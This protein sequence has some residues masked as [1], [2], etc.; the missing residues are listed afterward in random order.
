MELRLPTLNF[1]KAV[2]MF[3]QLSLID[4]AGFHEALL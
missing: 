2:E 4:S 1:E 3:E